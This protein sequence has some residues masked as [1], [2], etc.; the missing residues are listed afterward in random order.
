MHSPIAERVSAMAKHLITSL[1]ALNHCA[2]FPAFLPAF[3]FHGSVKLALVLF[4]CTLWPIVPLALTVGASMTIT[5][6][7][8]CF[9]AAAVSKFQ[10]SVSFPVASVEHESSSTHFSPRFQK[11]PHSGLIHFPQSSP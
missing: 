10:D 6:W 7:T 4:T 9:N 3:E 2:T 5:V 11:S 1:R 8:D